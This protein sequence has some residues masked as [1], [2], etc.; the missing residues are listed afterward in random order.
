MDGYA[1]SMLY[2]DVST[3]EEFEMQCPRCH[4]VMKLKT[5]DQY[6]KCLRCGESFYIEELINRD[7]NF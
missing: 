7:P 3:R 1:E 6:C 4:Q 2:D 5:T